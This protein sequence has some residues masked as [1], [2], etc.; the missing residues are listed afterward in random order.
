VWPQDKGD[1]NALFIR[2]K[3]A[4]VDAMKKSEYYQGGEDA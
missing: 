3:N 4:N 1:N 2:E